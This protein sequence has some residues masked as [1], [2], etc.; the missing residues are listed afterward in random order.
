MPFAAPVYAPPA[1]RSARARAV[2]RERARPLLDAL[3]E[4]AKTLAL[5][6]DLATLRVTLSA[7]VATLQPDDGSV[8]AMIRRAD[9]ALYTAKNAGRDRVSAIV[10]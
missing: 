9:A 7:G 1:A 10:A 3:R 6:A 8:E 5:P 4:A 2:R